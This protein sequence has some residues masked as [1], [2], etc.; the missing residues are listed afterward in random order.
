MQSVPEILK[1]VRK[2]ELR[3]RRFVETAF[4]GQYHSVFKG[5]GMNFDEFRQYDFGDEVRSIDWNVTARMGEP[6]VRKYIE[7]RELTVMLLIDVS[8]SGSLRQRECQQERTGGGSRLFAGLLRH[9]K[10][11]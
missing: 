3:T 5:R 8:A 11:R 4:A 9:P 2:L 10:Q 7:E 6:Y 1:K